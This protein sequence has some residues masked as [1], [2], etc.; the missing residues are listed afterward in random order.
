[1]S[2]LIGDQVSGRVPRSSVMSP[3]P[4][5]LQI[6]QSLWPRV[7]LLM[8]SNWT[9]CFL[10]PFSA[11]TAPIQSSPCQT[12][13]STGLFHNVTN[14]WQGPAKSLL[15]C[16]TDKRLVRTAHYGRSLQEGPSS[17]NVGV[18]MQHENSG[19]NFWNEWHQMLPLFER[20][21]HV[22]WV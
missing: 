3:S 19:W 11:D 5:M 1:M 10:L 2:G 7:S 22:K 14:C 21:Y 16:V 15:D 8:A 13:G 4:E 6:Q 9:W 12:G 18:E 20:K 17:W